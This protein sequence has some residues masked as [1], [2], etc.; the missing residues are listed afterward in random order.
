VIHIYCGDGKGKTTASVGLA[1]RAAGSGLRVLFAQ[2][3]K[4]RMTGELSVLGSISNITVMRAP[5]SE[6]FTYQ[7]TVDELKEN[8]EANSKFLAEV[9]KKARDEN[10][11]VLVLDEGI[12][13]ASADLLT[14]EE[15]KEAME[16]FDKNKE[17]VL[18]GR[19]PFQW[20]IEDADYVTDMEKIKHPFDSGVQARKGIE[21]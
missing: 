20:M 17:L 4:A 16:G 3:L 5:A 6:K 13:A 11:D 15:L 8:A 2:F 12:T 10:Y 18:T 9:L 21:F 14:E 19:V 7:M 1:V